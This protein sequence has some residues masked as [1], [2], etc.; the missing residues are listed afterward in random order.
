MRG[1]R[2]LYNIISNLV[3]QVIIVIYG[4][5]VPRVIIG[6]FGS[7]V[8]GLISSVT[9][10]LAYITLLESGFGPVVR[11]T[12]YKPIAEKNKEAIAGILRTTE[13]FFRRIAIIFIIYILILCCVFPMIVGSSFDVVFT[14]SLVVIIGISTFAEYFFGMTYRLFLQAEQKTYVISI[15]QVVTYIL[16]AIAVVALA[17]FGANVLIIKLVSGLIFTLRPLVQNFYVKKKYNIKLGGASK[18]YP[19][20]QKWDG[21]AQHVAAVIHGNTDITV[22][23]IFTN[24]AEVSVYAVYYLVVSGVKRIVQ[25]F[26][27]GIDATFGDMIA[28][29]EDDNLRKKFSAYEL[30]YMVL[31]TIIFTCTLALI[32]PFVTVYT[33]GVTDADY[34][35]PLFGYLLVASEFIWA[36]RAPYASLTLA[37]GHFKETRKGA[38]VEAIVNI[39]ISVAL[40]WKLGLVGVAIGTTVAMSIRAIEFIYHANKY[41]LKQSVGESVKK[42]LIAII[43]MVVAMTILNFIGLAEPISYVVWAKN[44]ALVLT[45]SGVVT[46]LLYGIF[47]GREL[48]GA[49]K[50]M[51][52]L[53]NRKKKA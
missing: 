40:V 14:V 11:A 32:T 21:L 38:W 16:S 8:N 12:L 50:K 35:R 29:K 43:A 6:Y 28:K 20:K 25:S 5:I 36:I 17:V 46:L 27:V 22:L 52:V 10:F 42:I 7:E 23:T 31:M 45:I 39:V 2:A 49:M 33:A 37:A 24:L 44:A 41:V 34:I 48:K 4:F 51:G 3:L 13:K 53:L 26:T 1:K 19:I 30:L 47:Y 18:D 15:I 9:Q